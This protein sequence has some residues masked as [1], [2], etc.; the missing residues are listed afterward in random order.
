MPTEGRQSVQPLLFNLDWFNIRGIIIAA[1]ERS[2]A[3]VPFEASRA[4]APGVES[5]LQL[6]CARLDVPL[7]VI[8]TKVISYIVSLG[9]LLVIG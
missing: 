1:R 6:F 8:S 3:P 4:G 2:Q 5:S 9:Y 7:K